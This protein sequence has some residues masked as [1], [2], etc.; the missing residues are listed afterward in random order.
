MDEF[1]PISASHARQTSYPGIVKPEE[2]FYIARMRSPQ[3]KD[4][5]LVAEQVTKENHGLWSQYMDVQTHERSAEVAGQLA[6]LKGT[7]LDGSRHFK[8][9]LREVSYENNDIFV[10]YITNASQPVKIVDGLRYYTHYTDK[11]SFADS[12]ETFVTMTSSPKALICSALG[13]ASALENLQTRQKG[14]GLDVLSFGAKVVKMRHP[15]CKF[16]INAPVYTV[17]NMVAKELPNSTFVG[18]REQREDMQKVLG[19]D[20]EEFISLKGAS[21]KEKIRTRAMKEADAE[22]ENLEDDLRSLR[23]GKRQNATEDSLRQKAVEYLDKYSLVEMGPEGRFVISEAKMESRYIKRLENEFVEFKNPDEFRPYPREK[24]SVEFL[25][26]MEQHPP[27]LSGSPYKVFTI[28]DPKQPDTPWLTINDSNRSDY[29]WMSKGVFAP[30]GNTHYMV[31]EL[32]PLANCRPLIALDSQYAKSLGYSWS[33]EIDPDMMSVRG[34]ESLANNSAVVDLTIYSDRSIC[35]PLYRTDYPGLFQKGLEN[36]PKLRSL[37]I[38]GNFY[39]DDWFHS[40]SRCLGYECVRPQTLLDE[41]PHL[42]FF[43]NLEELQVEGHIMGKARND[44][45]FIADFIPFLEKNYKLKTF[46]YKH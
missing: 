7:T 38:K 4:Q 19:I 44:I 17:E 45:Y 23:E 10:I 30:A 14:T 41:N 40:H 6:G 39:V 22:N 9:V 43:A 5:W 36:K 15:N 37:T 27:I 33:V 26:C 28:F 12:I 3:G 25:K 18:T 16:M 42:G 32:D 1:D 21:I 11:N 46:N 29:D 2:G 31:V 8:R 24:A 20:K 35:N 13:I 34:I